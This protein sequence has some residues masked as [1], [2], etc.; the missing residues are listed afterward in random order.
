[1]IFDWPLMPPTQLILI[2]S[3]LIAIFTCLVHCLYLAVPPFKTGSLVFGG[4]LRGGVLGAPRR[5][6]VPRSVEVEG[7]N[8]HGLMVRCYAERC[9][10]ERSVKS[11]AFRERRLPRAICLRC[12]QGIELGAN[13]IHSGFDDGT[14]TWNPKHPIEKMIEV[15]FDGGKCVND[16]L[17]GV[18]R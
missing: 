12:R 15:G 8:N 14:N 9:R 18:G 16:S 3:L 13:C 11:D 4:G 7:G 5:E 6:C 1:M 17:A 2:I 10:S